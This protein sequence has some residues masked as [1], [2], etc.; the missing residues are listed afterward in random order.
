MPSSTRKAGR[1]DRRDDDQ[2]D[3]ARDRRPDLDDALEDQVGPAAEIALDRL[4]DADDRGSKPGSARTARRCGSRRSAAPPRRGPDH[5]CRS[6]FHSSSRQVMPASS[7]G[8]PRHCSSFNCPGRVGQGP[9]P[10]DRGCAYGRSSGSAARSPK[11]LH[12]VSL[13]CSG[14]PI[15][16]G[17]EEAAE[18]LLQDS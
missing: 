15:I 8:I 7:L 9:E 14:L 1:Y 4:G 17:G 13:A 6:Q 12:K 10:A 11:P 16:G 2:K 18:L 5:R 3:R